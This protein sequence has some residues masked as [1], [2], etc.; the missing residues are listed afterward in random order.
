MHLLTPPYLLFVGDAQ[1]HVVAKTALG[2]IHW[3]PQLVAGQLRYASEA[4]DLG[5]NDMTLEEAAEGGARTL[6]VGVAPRGGQLPGPWIDTMV[7]ALSA[8]LDVAAGLHTRLA[9]IPRIA[10]AAKAAGR[11]VIDVRHTDQAIP[12]ATGSPRPGKRLLT[13]GTDCG[14]G[15]KFTALALDEAMRARGL[16]SDFRATGQTGILISGSGIAVDAVVAD[17]IAGAAELISPANDPDHWDIVEGQGSLF[18]PS[19]SGVSL[20]LLHGTQPDAIVICHDHD[21]THIHGVEAFELPTLEA[22]IEENIQLGRRTNP[23]IRCVGI[24][25]NTS[26]FSDADAASVM[27]EIQSRLGLPCV[28]PIRNSVDPILDELLRPVEAAA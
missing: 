1:N 25:L 22:C 9:A 13:V 12:L 26:R 14:S 18:H 20:G 8:G 4:F 27:N 28:D 23:N 24:S 11:R 17:F 3:R 19:Y 15:K 2:I 6:V 10:Q 7:A 21:R 16:S 5:V